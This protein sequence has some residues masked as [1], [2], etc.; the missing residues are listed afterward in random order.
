MNTRDPAAVVVKPITDSPLSSEMANWKTE[1]RSSASGGVILL[2][3]SSISN[4]C[5]WRKANAGI[6]EN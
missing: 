4:P 2:L 6:N 1:P 3:T 5:L